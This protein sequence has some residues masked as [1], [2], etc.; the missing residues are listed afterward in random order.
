MPETSHS[1]GSF[2][3]F[4]QNVSCPQ[5]GPKRAERACETRGIDEEED[6]R[7]RHESPCDSAASQKG[8][9]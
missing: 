2:P 1:R 8:I 3:S 7:G 6:R 9:C 4:R 5:Y